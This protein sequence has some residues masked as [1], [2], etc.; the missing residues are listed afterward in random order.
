M[1]VLIVNIGCA[2]GIAEGTTPLLRGAAMNETGQ[3]QNAWILIEGDRISGFGS[4]DNVPQGSFDTI[5][6]KGGWA[7][8]S[9]CD[10]HTHI[11]YAGSREQEFEDKIRGLSYEDI[12]KRGGGILNSAEGLRKISENELYEQSMIRV[13]E[14]IRKG[15]GAIEIKSGYGLS[16]ESELKMLRVIRRIA[17][18]VPL[19][20]KSTFLGA[21]A[22]PAEFRGDKEGYVRLIC[23]EMLPE[24]ARENLADYVDVF[25]DRGFFSVDDTARIIDRA[26]EFGIKAKIHADELALTGGTEIAVGKGAVSVDHLEQITENEM[27]FLAGGTTVPT[28]LPGASFFSNLPFAPVRQ[29]ID[30]GIGPALASDYNPGSSP[31][32]DMRFIMSLGCI[33]MR[34]SPVEAFNATTV[35]GAHAMESAHLAGT[36]TVG[37]LA[38][39]FITEPLP[40]LAFLPYAYITPLIRRIILK[41]QSIA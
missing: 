33:K 13:D 24:I 14:V 27:S 25:C 16:L 35:N 18:S 30:Y 37:K 32:G 38:N 23:R 7:F 36:I 28:A 34:M 9:F 10:S 31:S 1:S 29:M 2:V 20:V 15:T 8:P 41:G 26:A 21:H 3:I 40:S 6:A 11:V 39:L 4:M 12:A 5:D 22:V 19:V 17:E